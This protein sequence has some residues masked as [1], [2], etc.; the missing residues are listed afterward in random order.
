MMCLMLIM[1]FPVCQA[2]GVGRVEPMRLS[3]VELRQSLAEV[4]NRVQDRGERIAI[5][6]RGKDA[7]AIIPIE[8]LRLLERLIEEAEDRIDFETARAAL[9]ESDVRL[10]Y[11]EVRASLGLSKVGRR[12]DVYRP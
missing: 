11:E 12:R 6:R 9:E 4:L 8:D 1:G 5:H 2:G 10:P 7:A 3:V